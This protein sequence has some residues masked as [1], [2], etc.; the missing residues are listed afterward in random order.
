M[1]A[2]EGIDCGGGID[3]NGGIALTRIFSSSDDYSYNGDY[4]DN[5]YSFNAAKPLSQL[6]LQ[7]QARQELARLAMERKNA[8]MFFVSVLIGLATV[9]I[10]TLSI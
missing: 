10:I 7:E 3:G 8:T 4:S 2:F 1:D 9:F 5:S 6:E